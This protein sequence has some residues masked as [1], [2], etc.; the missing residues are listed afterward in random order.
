METKRRKIV[1]EME[2]PM[3][4]WY[5]KQRGSEPQLAQ[6]RRQAVAL[7]SGLAPGAAVLEVAPGPGY[8]S[9]ELARLGF[10]VTGLD[11]SHTF[12]S[13]AASRA[14]AE[15]VTVDFRH[16]DVADL[17]FPSDS[18]D[19]VVCQAAFKNFSSPVTAL[20]QIHRVLRPG[21]VAVIL[22]MN[23]GATGADIR[24]DVAGMRLNAFNSSV[25]RLTLSWLRSRAYTAADF[26]RVAAGSAFHGSAAHA[27][28]MTLEVRLTK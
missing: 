6:W 18:F 10:A 7:G 11:I 4:R 24:A 16:G 22:D 23:R 5:A 14:R 2:G 12:V 27:D 9:I 13:L 19:L 28:G 1:P 15:G 25:T 3:A 21:G 8:L 17:P 20:D 26:E